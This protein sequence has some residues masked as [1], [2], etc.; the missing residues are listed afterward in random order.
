MRLGFFSEKRINSVLMSLE[1]LGFQGSFIADFQNIV[2]KV[3][4]AEIK[5][6]GQ[7]WLCSFRIVVIRLFDCVEYIGFVL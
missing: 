4:D 1:R 7:Y 3:F 2:V 5:V 6:S